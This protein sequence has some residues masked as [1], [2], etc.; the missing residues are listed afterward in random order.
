MRFLTAIAAALLLAGCQDFGAPIGGNAAQSPQE[1]RLQAIETRLAD[2]TRKVENLN[3]AAQSQGISRLESEMRALRG[4]V[5]ALRYQVETNEKRS[6]ELYQDLDRRMTRV[7]NEG[8]SRLSLE[9]KIAAPPPV[10][11]AQEEEVMYLATFEKVRNAQYDDAIAGFEDLLQRWPGGRYAD[12]AWYWMGEAHY[13]KRDY[14][15]AMQSFG[16]VLEKFPQSA[17]A[18]DAL[19]KIGMAQVEKKQKAEARA[20][21]QRVVADFPTSNAA[22][23]AKQRLA[24][25]K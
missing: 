1:M 15:L 20:T 13:A 2:V 8:R 21:F 11:P 19:L 16:S 24:Q 17:K 14:D 22:N 4:E 25:L 3:F 7:E 10:P 6:R 5:E 23:V 9:P 12:N 18:P